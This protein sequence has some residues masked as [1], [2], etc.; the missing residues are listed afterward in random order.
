MLLVKLKRG[1]GD[2]LLMCRF[3]TDPPRVPRRAKVL[4][5]VWDQQSFDDDALEHVLRISLPPGGGPAMLGVH[6]YSAHRREPCQFTISISV[7]SSS[8]SSTGPAATPR[9]Q[10]LMDRSQR[11]AVRPVMA[12]KAAAEAIEA[13]E[14]I[15]ADEAI[16]AA[17]AAEATEAANAAEAA[18]A[19]EE[20]VMPRPGAALAHVLAAADGAVGSVGGGAAGGAARSAARGAG[21]GTASKASG[22]TGFA[23]RGGAERWGGSGGAV[24]AA[25]LRVE[26][27]LQGRE[28]EMLQEEARAAAPHHPLRTAL[29]RCPPVAPRRTAPHPLQARRLEAHA[30]RATHARAAAQHAAVAAL[31]GRRRCRALALAM[32]RWVRWACGQAR[33][34]AMH[35]G[36]LLR[37]ELRG[38]ER[39]G[40]QAV[41]AAA[42]AERGTAELLEQAAPLHT[43]AH[44]CTHM[45]THA[46]PAHSCNLHTLFA[47]A[48]LN[49]VGTSARAITRARPDPKPQP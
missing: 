20:A 5:D 30:E 47:S 12:G 16:N 44:P 27:Q 3:G 39:R 45:H 40:E 32:L 34:R 18:S 2:P 13:I 37:A 15:E 1:A 28:C 10:P 6:N 25:D 43:P 49:T 35:E 9:E 31:L 17:E 11:Q 48:L 33:E 38:A 22:A 4:A 41:G 29:H 23:M 8:P 42:E 7:V 46:H 24:S 26:L 14:A 19:Y 21:R 36:A